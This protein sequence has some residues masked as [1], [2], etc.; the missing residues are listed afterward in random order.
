[1]GKRLSG[2]GNGQRL[3]APAKRRC[4]GFVTQSN[5]GNNKDKYIRVRF[6]YEVHVYIAAE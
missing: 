4:G 3:S 2:L 6:S 1:M 5:P